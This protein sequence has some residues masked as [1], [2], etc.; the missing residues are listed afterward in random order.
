LKWTPRWSRCWI[1]GWIWGRHRSRGIGWWVS[2][3]R[4]V[5]KSSRRI[6]S[7]F[8]TLKRSESWSRS[9]IRGWI[10]GR[11]RSRGIGWWVS[12]L[13][14]VNKSNRRIGWWVSWLRGDFDTL[15]RSGSRSRSGWTSE[16]LS[17][18]INILSSH[19]LNALDSRYPGSLG[20]SLGF[21]SFLS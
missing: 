12:W 18:T 9:W 20:S 7:D 5:N 8:H 2:W 21:G 16:N 11:H 19:S 6:G 14:G 13:R 3:L 17:G 4:G 1:R 10:W 15:N